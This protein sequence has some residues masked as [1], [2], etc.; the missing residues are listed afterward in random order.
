MLNTK[1]LRYNIILYMEKE[2]N[3][4]KISDQM[5]RLY[6][7]AKDLQGWSGQSFIARELG[8]SPQTLNNWEA[9]PI[10]QEGLI[11]AQ[12]KIGC[13]AIWLRDGIGDMTQRKVSGTKDLSDAA[14]LLAIYS[15]LDPADRQDVLNF[16]RDAHRASSNDAVI[17]NKL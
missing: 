14:E 8:M 7:A 15:Q 3:Q 11:A 6:R 10:S 5:T 2:P 13:D 16:A 12:E 1:C 9:R 17:D 4:K